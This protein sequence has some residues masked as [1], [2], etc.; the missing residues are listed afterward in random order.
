MRN[1]QALM[2]DWCAAT[3]Y[4]LP[5]LVGRARAAR[6]G[7]LLSQGGHGINAPAAT[8]RDAAVLLLSILVSEGWKEVPR[9]VERYGSLVLFGGVRLDDETKVTLSAE[10]DI[11]FFRC[12]TTLLQA[13]AKL[14]EVYDTQHKYRL[15]G[16][17]VT[18]SKVKPHAH[19]TISIDTI[20]STSEILG[21]SYILPFQAPEACQLEDYHLEVVKA[22]FSLDTWSLDIMVDLFAPN[23]AAANRAR[24]QDP[25]ENGPPGDTDGPVPLDE[26]PRAAR[27]EATSTHLEASDREKDS[28]VGFRSQGDSSGGA[29]VPTRKEC[30]DDD[31]RGARAGPAQPCVA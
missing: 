4:P 30:P 31:A 21:D 5:D 13:L 27:P 2:R 8:A 24:S 22:T 25:H 6:E 29:S 16:L 20:T 28:Q 9:E 15:Y 17:S 26:S 10:S 3:G 18:R 12:G 7:G 19:L 14:I 11:L 1:V 23:V